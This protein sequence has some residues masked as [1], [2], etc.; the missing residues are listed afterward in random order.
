LNYDRDYIKRLEAKISALEAVTVPTET[1]VWE[2]KPDGRIGMTD[3]A[4]AKWAAIQAVPTENDEWP[5]KAAMAALDREENWSRDPDNSGWVYDIQGG[6]RSILAAGLRLPVPVETTEVLAGLAVAMMGTTDGEMIPS[7]S[8]I[9]AGEMY[10]LASEYIASLMLPLVVPVE[11]KWEYGTAYD[12]PQGE[13]VAMD[14]VRI[15]NVV[16]GRRMKRT[17]GAPAGEWQPVASDESTEPAV[18]FRDM[19]EPGCV[20][21]WPECFS[22]GYDPSCC[23]FPKSCSVQDIPAEPEFVDPEPWLYASGKR[24]AHPLPQTRYVKRPRTREQYEADAVT[25]RGGA[26]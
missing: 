12:T 9:P 23:R 21:A 5:L 17:M 10:R 13:V 24:A 7:D 16:A 25:D 14:G 22:G 18:P 2:S 1:D 26:S 15:I 3:S 8:E 11:P 19:R 4:K 6:A 20:E